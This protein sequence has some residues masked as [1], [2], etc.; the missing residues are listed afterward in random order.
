MKLI[1]VTLVFS[2]LALVFVGQTKAQ[3]L[4]WENW[5]SCS[6]IGAKAVASLLRE[7]IPTVRTLLNCVDFNP[8]ANIGTSY[9]SKLKLYYELLRRGAFEKSQCL[10]APL[11]ESVK[12][13][14]PYVKSLETSN[15]L[16]R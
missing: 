7:T 11:K 9:L 16:G 4:A 13:L 3:N 2:L 15:C 12:I 5:L 8:P 6:K 10:L 1:R 14:R